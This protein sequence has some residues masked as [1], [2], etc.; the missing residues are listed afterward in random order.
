VTHH[1]S[2]SSSTMLGVIGRRFIPTPR[3][4]RSFTITVIKGFCLLSC[5]DEYM[6]DLRPSEGTSMLPTLSNAHDLIINVRLPFY[7]FLSSPLPDFIRQGRVA[8]YLDISGIPNIKGDASMGTGIKVGDLVSARSPRDP[9]KDVCKRV[10][11]L[12]GDT[13]L[14]DPRIEPSL[15]HEQEWSTTKK[16]IKSDSIDLLQE[17]VYIT[18]PKGHVW[19]VGDNLGNSLDSRHYGPVPLGLVKGRAVAKS[20]QSINWLPNTVQPFPQ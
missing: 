1:S 10:M 9:M 4:A 18:I 20:F 3:G 16:G 8:R 12:P 19:L 7:R 11:G 14:L 5:I 2:C 15:L 17:P 13:I 6:I